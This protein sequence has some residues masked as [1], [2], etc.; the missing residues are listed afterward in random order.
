MHEKL[1]FI[2]FAA[3]QKNAP[4][5]LCSGFRVCKST[6]SIWV[7][8]HLCF[9]PRHIPTSIL[10]HHSFCCRDW[11][12]S[13]SVVCSVQ[14]CGIDYRN[15]CLGSATPLKRWWQR[16]LCNS[17]RSSRG[18]DLWLLPGIVWRL[19]SFLWQNQKCNYWEHLWVTPYKH[20]VFFLCVRL[21]LSI[22]QI[23]TVCK[24]TAYLG[25]S[26]EAP[27]VVSRYLANKWSWGRQFVWPD[28]S[29]S[30][31][32]SWT[33]PPGLLTRSPLNIEWPGRCGRRKHLSCIR[34]AYR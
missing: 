26:I 4:I 16:R 34:W 12:G 6:S 30:L 32:R 29:V 13:C 7:L 33:A 21:L 22:W 15:L 1:S 23:M 2:N 31:R 3:P 20:F 14:G 25:L 24:V 5:C 19:I 17:Q 10:W 8:S 28:S 9:N 18:R 11:E 27:A